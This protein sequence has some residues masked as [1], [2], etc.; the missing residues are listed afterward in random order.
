MGYKNTESSFGSV[1]KILHWTI[2]FCFLISYCSA[3]YGLWFTEDE[4]YVNTIVIQIHQATGIV[5]AALVA[6]RV[7]W[8]LTSVLPNP[9]LASWYEHL[10][11]RVVHAALYGVMIMMPV[12]GYFGTRRDTEF[13]GITRFDYTSTWTSIEHAFDMSWDRFEAPLDYFHR[14]LGGPAIVWI[15]IA[16]HIVGALYHHY[17]RRDDTLTRM[18]PTRR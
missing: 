8:R 4:T 18:L 15:L 9:P 17:H 12:T 1:T 7:A 6:V 14:D 13:L 3:Y 2:A 10:A 5:A 16:I 11:A